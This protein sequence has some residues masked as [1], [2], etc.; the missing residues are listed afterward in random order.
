[1]KGNC[2]FLIAD[3]GLGGEDLRFTYPLSPFDKLRDR[4][5]SDIELGH[6]RFEPSLGWRI[7][8]PTGTE[9]VA[10]VVGWNSE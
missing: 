5:E 4:R 9:E 8:D 7:V 2:G 1:M 6:D 10:Y 3:C